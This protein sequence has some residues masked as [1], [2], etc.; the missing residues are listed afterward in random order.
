MVIVRAFHANHQSSNP[1]DVYNFSCVK[2]TWKEQLFSLNCIKKSCSK[3]IGRDWAICNKKVWGLQLNITSTTWGLSVYI[4]SI[5][6]LMPWCRFRVYMD[7]MTTWVRKERNFISDR[8]CFAYF[9]LLSRRSFSFL[10]RKVLQFNFLFRNA[11]PEEAFLYYHLRLFKMC[12][13]LPASTDP[14]M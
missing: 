7:T 14:C 2:I 9:K 12:L 13:C 4:Y 10:N 11:K 3:N 8:L 5:K 1:F 6:W